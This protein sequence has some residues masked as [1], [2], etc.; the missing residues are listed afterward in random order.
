MKYRGAQARGQIG[1]TAT[2]LHHSHSTPDL[3]HIWE[4]HHSSWHGWILNPLNRARDWTHILMDT[5]QIYYHWVTMGTPRV[6]YVFTHSIWLSGKI[7]FPWF[8]SMLCFFHFT[9]CSNPQFIYHFWFSLKYY[10]NLLYYLRN[11]PWLK[12]KVVWLSLSFPFC[13]RINEEKEN[14]DLACIK[15]CIV[16]LVF[17]AN[18]CLLFF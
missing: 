8:V 5:S 15:I 17:I 6:F 12:Q 16:H 18:F 14:A 10:L 11:S 4:L 7:S 13:A 9:P 2:G 3:S 1:A